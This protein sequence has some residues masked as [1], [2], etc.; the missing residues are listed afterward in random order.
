MSRPLV[1][2]LVPARNEAR[3]I[4]ACID[5]I[6]A[7]DYPGELMEV[8]V[9]DG[10]STDETAVRAQTAIERSGIRCARV[11]LN[12]VGTTP[13][14]LNVG[15]AQASGDVVCRID[16]RT[17]VAPHHV[18]TCVELLGARPDVAV[19]GG[20]QHSIPRDSS[21]R[22]IGIA[23]ALNNRYGMGWSRYRRG[24][25]SGPSD[26]VYLGSFRTAD[27]RKVGGWDERLGTNQDF[28]LNRR[29]GTVGS[30][31]FDEDLVSGYLPRESLRALWQQYVRFGRWKV[32][33][34]VL[35][36]DRPR[37]RQ[38]VL[39]ATPPL[40]ASGAALVSG[41]MA[42]RSGRAALAAA[43]VCG[44]VAVEVA[45][46][47]DPKG[48]PA[49]HAYGAVAMVVVAG[50]WLTGLWG[51]ALVR[52]RAAARRVGRAAERATSA[53]SRNDRER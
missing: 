32:H 31:W 8:L 48:G 39:A 3:D 52:A 7:Q 25:G 15:L 29:M 24:G 49:A 9:V 38:L 37:P 41:R 20:A 13:S 6:G 22:S 51:E 18:R 47:E 50:G 16:A 27:L 28:D 4:A 30:V 40:L 26:T 44:L 45:G 36:G 2:V 1:T 42:S 23:R 19:V 5:A 17:V 21:A 33:Y 34:W 12:P 43:G 35:T 46:A 53:P 10:G 11:L 14:N